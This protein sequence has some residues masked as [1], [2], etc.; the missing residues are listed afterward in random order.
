MEAGAGHRCRSPVCRLRRGRGGVRAAAHADPGRGARPARRQRPE[1]RAKTKAPAPVRVRA[2]A[3]RRRGGGARRSSGGARRRRR[4]RRLRRLRPR[5]GSGR[6]RGGAGGTSWI[7]VFRATSAS[8]SPE[9]SAAGLLRRA[10]VRRAAALVLLGAPRLPSAERPREPRV[11]GAEGGALLRGPC[12]A[13]TAVSL[14]LSPPAS[15]E[16]CV[17]CG[18]A[19]LG[20]SAGRPCPS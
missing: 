19:P 4:L 17:S 15:R 18:P 16:G 14:S 8:A 7:G 10:A 9:L 2:H 1:A 20:S 11:G 6:G 5:P 13:C 3:S 12:L